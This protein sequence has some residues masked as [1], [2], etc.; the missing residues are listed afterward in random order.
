MKLIIIGSGPAGYS[1]AF[2]AAKYK[3]DVQLFTN[4]NLG[5][6]CLNEGCIPTKSLLEDGFH[7]SKVSEMDV[8]LNVLNSIDSV[9]SHK[10]TIQN[11][12][13]TNLEK[14]LRQSKI[15]ILHSKVHFID[16]THVMDENGT[17]Y[18]A[19]K[20]I[21]C[22]GARPSSPIKIEGSLTSYN[23]LDKPFKTKQSILIIGAGV[24]GV[25]LASFLNMM[26]HDVTLI[27]LAP[28]ILSQIPK[29]AA[30]TL[31]R[32]LKRMGIQIYTNTKLDNWTKDIH[33]HVEFNQTKV[34]FDQIIL[35]T[36][37]IA[38]TESLK[39][40]NTSIELDRGFIKVNDNFETNC[41]NIYACGDVSGAIQLAHVASD[42]GEQLIDYLAHN[43]VIENKIIPYV[44]YTPL[45]VAY[46]GITEE[47]AKE[48]NLNVKIKKV[49]ISSL[50]KQKIKLNTRSYLKCI[51]TDKYE[52]IGVEIVSS[53]A[54]EL[55][56]VCLVLM[57]NKL[58]CR[59]VHDIIYAHPSLS[60]V[61]KDLKFEL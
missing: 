6:V 61:F 4:H 58:D 36:G 24:I 38:N 40:E 18:T 7:L 21:I 2:Q 23:V 59:N 28:R 46:A 31:D 49:L 53:D 47:Q 32:E 20:F 14:A 44:I 26:S 9:Y 34:D 51:V 12:L 37:R 15:E 39:L 48:L 27:E 56:A 10:N 29:E 8:S 30:Q 57:E 13:Q 42:Q 5:G 17:I 45:Q 16:N 35:A 41:P 43:K 54:S 19:D 50:A 33:Y 55:I 60:E 22:T 52:M 3:W 11:E 25:E 1:A